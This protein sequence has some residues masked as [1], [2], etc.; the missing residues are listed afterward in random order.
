MARPSA[1]DNHHIDHHNVAS[2][3]ALHG[4]SSIAP[5]HGKA[6]SSTI[7]EA[8]VVDQALQNKITITDGAS[9]DGLMITEGWGGVFDSLDSGNMSPFVLANGA[10]VEDLK[11][12][13]AMQLEQATSITENTGAKL[14]GNTG[15]VG[16]AHHE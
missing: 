12:V 11:G 3:E 16:G 1:V 9:M 4:G 10:V 13:G 14:L 5:S 2:G 6:F 8:S 7:G 15:V